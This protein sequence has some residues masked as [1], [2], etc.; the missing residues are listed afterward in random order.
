MVTVQI[1][2]EL[3]ALMREADEPVERVAHGMIVLELYRR[4]TISSG[5]EA[6]L[7]G[8]ERADFIVHASRLGIPFFDMTDEEWDAEVARINARALATGADCERDDLRHLL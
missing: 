7:L 5:R 8:M 4:H 1:N 2:D 3:A 6:E